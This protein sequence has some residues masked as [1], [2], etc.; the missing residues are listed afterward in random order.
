M[1]STETCSG[2]FSVIAELNGDQY[3][4]NCREDQT[5][6]EAA[7]DAGFELPVSCGAGMCTVCAARVIAGTVDQPGAMGVKQELQDAG[8]TLLCV[9]YPRSDLELS[10][11]QEDAL[12]EAQFGQVKK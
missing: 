11:G 3:Q 4:F 6:L 9:A 12:Y 7:E 1:T 2:T 10:A 5:V 8:F